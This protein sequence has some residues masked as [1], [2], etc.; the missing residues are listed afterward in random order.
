MD[1]SAYIAFLL[2]QLRRV[3][4]LSASKLTGTSY[5]Q[6]N[7]LLLSCQFN[8]KDTLEALRGNFTLQGNTKTMK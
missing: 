2:S 4:C 5:H 3:S 6:V 1:A 7:R 8:G